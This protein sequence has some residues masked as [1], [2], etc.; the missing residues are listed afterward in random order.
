V[1]AGDTVLAADRA[2]GRLVALDLS[3]GQQRAAVEVGS[4]S[5][6][7][8]PLLAGNTAVVGTMDGVLVVT[9]A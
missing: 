1:I 2:A 5:R 3:S 6:F 8:T 4:V 7:A 9:L